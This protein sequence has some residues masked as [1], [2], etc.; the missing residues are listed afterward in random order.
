MGFIL[1]FLWQ[2]NAV[3]STNID[4]SEQEIQVAPEFKIF[5]LGFE[6]FLSEIY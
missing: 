2:Q 3:E 4:Q 6:I 5:Q 1:I